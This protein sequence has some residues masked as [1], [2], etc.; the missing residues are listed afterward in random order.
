M[1]I[2]LC[3]EKLGVTDYHGSVTG[4]S[5]EEYDRLTVRKGRKPSWDELVA[6]A[7]G[8]GV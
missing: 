7:E 4:N 5:A 6:V 8:R 3:L 1:D 2:A